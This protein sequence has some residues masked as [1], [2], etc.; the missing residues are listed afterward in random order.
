M[1]QLPSKSWVDC[2]AD[3]YPP[4]SVRAYN[5]G[6]CRQLASFPLALPKIPDRHYAV[7]RVGSAITRGAAALQRIGRLRRLEGALWL[8]VG[9]AAWVGTCL[10][11]NAAKH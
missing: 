10:N 5:S 1:N 6:S 9:R 8:Q 7:T 11:R 2:P 4:W 3:I